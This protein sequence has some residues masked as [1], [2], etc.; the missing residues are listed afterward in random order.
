MATK[1]WSKGYEVD[2]LVERFEA[3]RNAALD[4]ELARHDIWGSLAHAR[5]LYSIGLLSE[6]E[7]HDI[8]GALCDLLREPGERTLRPAT[9]E[10]DIQTPVE[11]ALVARIGDT[12]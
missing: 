10:E 4:A 7:W 12:A 8:A 11:Q 6:D 5:M 2:P 3:A 1:L 9:V